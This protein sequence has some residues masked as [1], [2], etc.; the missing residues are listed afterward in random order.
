M[1]IKWYLMSFILPTTGYTLDANTLF[2]WCLEIVEDKSKADKT[3]RT[4]IQI[5]NQIPVG[6]ALRV[7]VSSV[8][9]GPSRKRLVHCSFRAA[10]FY[11]GMELN[12]TLRKLAKRAVEYM[13]ERGQ[14][15][16]WTI[17]WNANEQIDF[18]FEYLVVPTPHAVEIEVFLKHM[19]IKV[20]VDES[21]MEVSERM[22]RHFVFRRG[23]IFRIFPVNN[24][25]QRL[26][27]DDHAYSFDWGENHQYWFHIVRD[28][29]MDQQ[30]LCKEIRSVDGA[31]RVDTFV[32]P[33]AATPEDVATLWKKILDSPEELRMGM[34]RRND[35][36]Y[37]WGIEERPNHRIQCTL[38]S[39][40]AMET[41]TLYA[42]C[43]I[44]MADQ[45]CRVFGVKV[46]PF[47]LCQVSQANDGKLVE[48]DDDW[49]LLTWNVLREHALAW[50]LN[51]LII[52]TPMVT[53][54]W[55]P[56]NL[57]AMMR[58]G[59]TV[60]SSIPEDQNEAEFPPHPWPDRVVIRIKSQAAPKALLAPLPAG[61]DPRGSPPA[62]GLPLTW[63]GLALGQ[64]APISADAAARTGYR[65]ANES[66]QAEGQEEESQDE[67]V[68]RLRGQTKANE[69]VHKGLSWTCRKDYPLEVGISLPIWDWVGEESHEIQ[70]W[71]EVTEPFAAGNPAIDVYNW[72]LE[73]F[74]ARSE[75]GR[76]PRGMPE[77]FEGLIGPYAFFFLEASRLQ[78]T[79]FQS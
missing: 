23:T 46:P 15:E 38:K 19:K 1:G 72:L 14:G 31:G 6:F 30:N 50:N 12:A 34:S 28:A 61:G 33:G 22:V 24:E 65:S 60:N 64:A 4:V 7:R 3:K 21:W 47:D 51:G 62:S 44:F 70:Y 37:Y 17:E 45:L 29:N 26:G 75:S 43:D 53:T 48:Q 2:T 74:R 66:R 42:G 18:D 55:L 78:P 71:E 40:S 69:E 20:R 57:E 8:H 13:R 56:Y 49:P 39:R 36:E 5:P 58:Y 59:H 63:T 25:V 35:V 67:E 52:S 11:F 10:H 9:E 73:R 79:C 16:D 68:L 54:W 76:I 77:T 32:V 27:D 41:A